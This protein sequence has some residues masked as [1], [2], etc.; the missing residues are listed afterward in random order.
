MKPGAV[1]PGTF[2]GAGVLRL[3]KILAVPSNSP[4]WEGMYCRE[5]LNIPLVRLERSERRVLVP[6]ES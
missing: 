1:A 2:Q 4:E 5:P 3:P 6:E